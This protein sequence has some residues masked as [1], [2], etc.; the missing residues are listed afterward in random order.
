VEERPAQE[1][2]EEEL[3]LLQQAQSMERVQRLPQAFLDLLMS[4]QPQPLLIV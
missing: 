2:V 4:N 3:G 1:E